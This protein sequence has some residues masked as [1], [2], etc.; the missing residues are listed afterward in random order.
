MGKT[1][2]HRRRAAATEAGRLH[3]D[4]GEDKRQH[5]ASMGADVRDAYDA[6]YRNHIRQLEEAAERERHPLRLIAVR[7]RTI[8]H[9]FC[10]GDDP[11][12]PITDLAD[13]IVE[14]ADYLRDREDGL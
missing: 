8:I 10:E 6:G 5:Y 7:A 14:I 4:G 12:Q 11:T 1:I 9:S 2:W 3:A 13:M